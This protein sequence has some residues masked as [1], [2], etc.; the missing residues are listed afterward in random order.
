[1]STNLDNSIEMEESKPTAITN[2]EYEQSFDTSFFYTSDKSINSM[3]NKE[4]LAKIEKRFPGFNE[5]NTDSVIKKALVQ[6][7]M[8]LNL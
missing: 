6:A 2:S 3:D 1:M 5:N 7:L 8:I 4:M